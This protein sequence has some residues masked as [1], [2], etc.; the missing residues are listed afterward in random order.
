MINHGGWPKDYVKQLGEEAHEEAFKTSLKK[1]N[2]RLNTER[3]QQLQRT[4][5]QQLRTARKEP[6]SEYSA[7]QQ[8]RFPLTTNS[9]THNLQTIAG[10]QY[11]EA[12]DI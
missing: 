4:D 9:S 5:Q 1:Q 2:G 12:R 3:L 7:R 8:Q 11:F 6:A 10:N